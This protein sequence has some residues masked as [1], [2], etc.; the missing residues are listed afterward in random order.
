MLT[1][2]SPPQKKI[3]EK[4]GGEGRTGRRNKGT[5]INVYYVPTYAQISTVNLY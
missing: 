3:S 4:G 5:F 1:S 2:T